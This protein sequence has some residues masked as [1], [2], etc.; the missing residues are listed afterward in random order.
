MDDASINS[1][2]GTAEQMNCINSVQGLE[3]GAVVPPMEPVV[4]FDIFSKLL[5][6]S[7]EKPIEEYINHP[8]NYD[9][10]TSTG[11][12]IRGMEGILGALNY[13]IV[14][15]ILGLVEKWKERGTVAHDEV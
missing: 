13:A 7:P 15:M 4:K 2:I 1:S 6:I 14:D 10:K 8:L 11:R 9:S 3:P 12:I 5:S